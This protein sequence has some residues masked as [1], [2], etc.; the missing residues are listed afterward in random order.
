MIFLRSLAYRICF[1]KKRSSWKG[2]GIRSLFWKKMV[3]VVDSEK[4]THF[5]SQFWVIYT[6]VGC[7]VF[8][9]PFNR[10]LQYFYDGLWT[11]QRSKTRTCWSQPWTPSSSQLIPRYWSC[12]YSRT[13]AILTY[14]LTFYLPNTHQ[15]YPSDEKYPEVSYKRW[16]IK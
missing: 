1:P 12:R 14:F 2:R 16:N 10:T 13:D 9:I 3:Q 15:R 5:W 6:T 11:S 8:L 7:V 4:Q